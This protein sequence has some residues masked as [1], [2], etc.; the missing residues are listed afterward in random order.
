M[1]KYLSSIDHLCYYR[2]V[3]NTSGLTRNQIEDLLL[4]K[5]KFW[6]DTLTQHQ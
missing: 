1:S 4:E 5:E 3:N 2:M 6:M